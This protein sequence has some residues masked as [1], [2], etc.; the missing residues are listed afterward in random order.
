[1]K[2]STTRWLSLLRC[3]KRLLDQWPAL[4]SYFDRQTEEEPND[5]RVQRVL[6]SLKSFEVKLIYRFALFALQPIKK[7]TTVFQTHASRI[8]SIQDDTLSLLRGYL[9]NFIKPEVITAASDITTINYHDRNNQLSNDTLA[10]GTET[11]LF[12]SEFEDEIEGTAIE[13]KFFSVRV[14]YET[15]VSKLLAKFPHKDNTLSDLSFID[16][17]NRAKSNPRGIIRLC[18]RFMTCS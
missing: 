10:I 2:H 17:N 1:M 11:L 9:A 3:L 4:H 14:F 12:L 8:G 15:V 6:T 5:G 13:R 18:N 16:P 7:F